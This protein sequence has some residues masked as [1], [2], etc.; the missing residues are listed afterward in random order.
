MDY[1]SSFVRRLRPLVALCGLF[2]CGSVLA[3][4][5]NTPVGSQ[6]IALQCCQA[7]NVNGNSANGSGAYWTTPCT[8][9][10]STP[11]SINPDAVGHPS[12]YGT[13]C[14]GTAPN[15]SCWT[16][17]FDWIGS[18]APDTGCSG[19]A[20]G[21]GTAMGGTM[22]QAQTVQICNTMDYKGDYQN[23]GCVE[24]FSPAYG[25]GFD[26]S[27][28][29]YSV[30]TGMYH[31]TGTA[32]TP[33]TGGTFTPDGAST[34]SPAPPPTTTDGAKSPKSC[35]GGSCIDP[36]TGQACIVDSTGTQFCTPTN[37]TPPSSPPNCYSDGS[38]ATLCV[39]SPQAPTPSPSN[40][41][42]SNPATQI[43]SSDTYNAQTPG[44]TTTTTVNVYNTGTGTTSS[45][46]SS[47]DA[48][49]TAGNQPNSASQPAHASSAG[50]NGTLSGG[51][52][53]TSPPVCT[54]DSVLCGIARTQWSTTCQ[55]H[56]DLTG[57]TGAAPTASPTQYSASQVWATPTTGNTVGDAANNGQYDESGFG[58]MASCPL[59]DYTF[60]SVHGL[61]IPF[62]KGCTPISWL[63]LVAEGFALFV[64]AKITAGSNE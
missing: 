39:G 33:S 26:S 10:S 49:I 2:F 27:S 8:A 22:A 14:R 7:Q 35:G 6:S 18:L 62:S 23:K 5:C 41:S 3:L 12:F 9:V 42:V 40:S 55:I 37:S 46:Q 29:S 32:C 38:S 16:P 48:G 20:D 52:N 34:P 58:P 51:T 17:D 63:A 31:A 60:S 50:G 25:I 59:T 43:A 61:V 45:G 56:T 11:S 47:T 30:F 64:A 4:N 28:S 19:I 44:A 54:G 1:L 21:P 53:C 13:Y 15:N 57:P 24:T 36:S